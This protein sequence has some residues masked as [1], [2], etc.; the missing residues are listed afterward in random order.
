MLIIFQKKIAAIKCNIF[1]VY[2]ENEH[3][4]KLALSVRTKDKVRP[5]V[6]DRIRVPGS[7]PGCQRSKDGTVISRKVHYVDKWQ[8]LGC[9]NFTANFIWSPK[10]TKIHARIVLQIKT[11]SYII[12]P[13]LQLAQMVSEKFF[14]PMGISDTIARRFF[15]YAGS[16]AV[17]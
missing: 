4:S 15:L 10:L 13:E 5:L 9:Q 14:F 11:Y 3:A 16:S 12:I 1:F 8:L 6:M 17:Q 2:C 7:N